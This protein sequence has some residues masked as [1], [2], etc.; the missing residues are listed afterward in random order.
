MGVTSKSIELIEKVLS[1]IEVKEVMELGSQ[2]LFDKHYE[3]IK[4]DGQH[5]TQP[6][7]SDYYEAKGIKYNC[8]DLNGENNAYKFDLSEPIPFKEKYNLVTDFGTGEHVKNIY[9]VFKTIHNLLNEGGIAIRENPKT[10]N[11]PGHGCNYMT[12]DIYKKLAELCG[13]KILLLEEHPAMSNTTD[14]WNVIC[15]YQ[16][17]NDFKFISEDTFKQLNIPKK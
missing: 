10:G 14:G 3:N 9:Q 12:T 6:F 15:I 13:Y 11:W 7:A 2:N 16:K 1:L 5:S 17:T 4:H 8:I